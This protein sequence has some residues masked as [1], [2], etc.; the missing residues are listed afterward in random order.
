MKIPSSAILAACLAAAWPCA[1]IVVRADRDDSEYRELA[2]RYASAV[3]LGGYGEGVL[4]A[5]RWIL[6]SS[7]VATAL[8]EGHATRF[9]IGGSEHDIRAT[10]LSPPSIHG[11][12]A[13]ILLVDPVATI[14]PTAVHRARDE[15]G[16]P[17]VIAGHGAT[18]V[19]G[20]T[21]DVRDGVKR[22]AINTVDRVDD[23]RLYL[24]LKGPDDASDLQ[25]AAGAGDE[26]APAYLEAK[27][28][29]SVA[30]IAQG[31]RGVAIPKVGDEDVYTRI[32]AF[33][34]WIDETMFAAAAAEAEAAT[35]PR[36]RRR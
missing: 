21:H 13:L 5:P 4:I 3:A 31:P 2:S 26:G 28:R 1:A 36:T 20:T 6:T 7:S 9:R 10:F 24:R 22:A 23:A 18:G 12:I 35:A 27:G 29:L 8:R 19:I 11:D 16:K 17:V 32:S 25:G 15:A 30:G 33:T 14:E 34:A